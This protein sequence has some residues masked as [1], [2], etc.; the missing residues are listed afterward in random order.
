[1]A[2]HGVIFDLDGTLVDTLRDLAGSMNQ[3]LRSLG[4]SEHPPEAYKVFVGDGMLNLARRALPAAARREEVLKP[5]VAAL[6]E[7]YSWRWQEES[8]PYPGIPELLEELSRRRLTLGVLT[9]KP[10]DL[11]NIMVAAFFPKIPFAAVRGGRSG[12]PVKA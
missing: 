3:V 8:A 6:R 11:A 9:N 5:A 4:F 12:L 2:Y 7:A 1:M 10:D